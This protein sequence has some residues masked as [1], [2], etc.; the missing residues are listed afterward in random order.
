MRIDQTSPQEQ[1]SKVDT[2]TNEEIY[3]QASIFFQEEDYINSIL[4]LRQLL[5]NEVYRQKVLT[6]LGACLYQMGHYRAAK[7]Y[8]KK[9]IALNS[10]DEL[11]RLNLGKT[12]FAL[13]E[14]SNASS[15]FQAVLAA[16]SCNATAWQGAFDSSLALKQFQECL[17]IADRWILAFPQSEDP[18]FAQVI[19]LKNLG[20]ISDAARNL[21]SFDA[22][23]LD[24]KKYNLTMLDL[25]GALNMHEQALSLCNTAISE[26]PNE[27]RYFTYKG[28]IEL[29]LCRVHDSAASYAKASSLSPLSA[30]LFLNQFFLFPS[31]PLSGEEINECRLRCLEGLEKAESLPKLVLSVEHP[32]VP[33]TFS[34]A[35]HNQNDRGIL[36][37]YSKL[38]KRL[39]HPIIQSIISKSKNQK[40]KCFGSDKIRIG[41]L[42]KYFSAH[43]NLLAFEGVIRH[44]NRDR[45]QVILIHIEGVNKDSSHLSISSACD[46][47]VYLT[48]DL[49]TCY[50]NLH[51][52]SLDIL[53]FTDLGMTP[54]DFFIP[55]FRSAPLQLTGWGIPHTS[56][57][58]DIDFY[59]SAEG[60]EPED[61]QS[62]YTERLIELPGGLPCCF[63]CD[64]GQLPSVPREYFF[65]PQN[66]KLIG[67]L[68]SLHK[69]H[70][71]F[72]FVLEAIAQEN[73]DAIFIFV[74]NDIPECTRRFLARL[75]SHAPSVREQLLFLKTMSRAEYHGLC[76]CMD[77]L[78]DPIYYGSGITFF[79]ASLA[80]AIVVTL[81]GDYLRSRTVASG[82]RKM[83]LE[84]PPI[85][86]T[87]D[88]YVKISTELLND[89]SKR[90]SLQHDIRSKRNRIFNQLEYVRH[91]EDFCINAHQESTST[92]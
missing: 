6:S 66:V 28:G 53:Y 85:A 80:G 35:Y 67:C 42:S 56:G 50:I 57:S 77:I 91:F 90:Q 51:S 58:D 10:D 40:I 70:P 72:D 19:S 34:L 81:E 15:Y 47:V 71:D 43:S 2:P 76:S 54:Y 22:I 12:L 7:K 26:D 82:Y 4:F 14:F 74:E 20:R 63:L 92:R 25:L 65:L 33:H 88:E 21:A 79:E 17:Q 31:I 73:P 49:Y 32:I 45:F 41:F 38:M 27:L 89:D 84:N 68:Q 5:S 18:H 69:L 29:A 83:G 86:I 8:L 75:E 11:C 64:D 46:E 59:I 52:L 24:R 9:G 3:S 87:I 30:A 61:A 39:S 23:I 37:R 55:Y 44:L 16:N 60:A 48:D 78:L 36:E 62:H 1:P 13:G